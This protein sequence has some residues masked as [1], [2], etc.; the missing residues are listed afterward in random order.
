MLGR[1]E[2]AVAGTEP[3][4]RVLGLV[5][6]VLLNRVEVEI[7]TTVMVLPVIFVVVVVVVEKVEE[8]D[9]E[10]SSDTF[11]DAAEGSG[12]EV[13]N[14]S[15]MVEEPVT[16]FTTLEFAATE[17]VTIAGEVKCAGSTTPSLPLIP[18]KLQ[19]R[20]IT[21]MKLISMKHERGW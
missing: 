8:T 6:V 7:G 15:K 21:D 11:E 1:E 13:G 18:S 17:L 12:V 9:D 5:L 3:V 2:A 16:P 14:G 20:T 19:I 4:E 10:E